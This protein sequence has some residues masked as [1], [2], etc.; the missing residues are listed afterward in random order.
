MPRN[1]RQELNKGVLPYQ[2]VKRGSGSISVLV[3]VPVPG[4]GPQQRAGRP[5]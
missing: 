1:H 3:R 5:A 4:E 2:V